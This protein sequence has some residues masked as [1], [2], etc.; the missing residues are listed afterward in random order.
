LALVAQS[1]P[2]PD[3]G[4]LTDDKIRR[5]DIDT[6]KRWLRPKLGGYVAAIKDL[7]L[8]NRFYRGVPWLDRPRFLAD[9]SYPPERFA[10]LNRAS[11]E[12]QPMFYASLGA[13]PVFFELRAVAGQRIALSEWGV[14]EP[15]WMHNLG[16]HE[17]SLKRLGRLRAPARPQLSALIPRETK[18]NERLRR[19]LSLA[20]TADTS[21][22]REYRYKLS[23]AIN[24]LLF[25]KAEPLPFRPGGPRSDRVAGTAYPA[26]QMKGAADNIAIW[27]EFVDSCLS[28]RSVRY[29]VI[30]R[31]DADRSYT[32]LNLAI[33]HNFAGGKIA[34]ES[35]DG[36]EEDRRS[37]IEY[38]DGQWI[39][40]DGR[41]RIYDVH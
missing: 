24:E 4:I 12:G 25:D 29:V 1:H 36:P 40:R 7:A 2:N 37:H 9:V 41:G 5:H 15:I 26:M 10:R 14:I 18:Q 28:I 3:R 32:V 22:N 35:T 39:S 21:G 11:R 13:P 17:A 38:V 19:L 6:L 8:N 31:A 33:S 34:W 30:E 23:V 16:F 27:P 20:F